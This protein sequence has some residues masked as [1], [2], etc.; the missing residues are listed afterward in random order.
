MEPKRAKTEITKTQNSAFRNPQRSGFVVVVVLCMVMMLSVLLLGF[1][2]KSRV[3]LRAVDGV[4]KSERA[5]NCTR[6]GLNI[7]IAI[8]RDTN[9]IHKDK[10]LLSMLSGEKTFAV[11][12][13]GCSITIT[14]EN[15]K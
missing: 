12:N 1:N 14:E 3:N 9:D 4:R 6:A 15:S 10:T 7:A 5:L 2:Y 11:G 13:G 8:V